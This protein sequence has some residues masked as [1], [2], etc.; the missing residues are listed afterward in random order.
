MM[1]FSIEKTSPSPTLLFCMQICRRITEALLFL[2]YFDQTRFYGSFRKFFKT[3]NVVR[4][5]DKICSRIL[6]T[7]P[8]WHTCSGWY[9]NPQLLQP[10]TSTNSYTSPL[11]FLPEQFF[12]ENFSV[13]FKG[14]RSSEQCRAHS[15]NRNR[16]CLSRWKLRL[17][18]IV[19]SSLFLW[20]SL[21][22]WDFRPQLIV[23]SGLYGGNPF[24]D[25]ILGHNLLLS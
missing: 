25:G 10:W 14:T 12:R 15:L 20:E 3:S 24:V 19:V 6:W 2:E 4:Q 9:C 8:C 16:H 18:L 13:V 11:P 7:W 22:G 5:V 17:Q 21:R 1:T 23:V